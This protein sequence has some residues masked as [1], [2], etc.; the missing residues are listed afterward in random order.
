MTDD[1][2]KFNGNAILVLTYFTLHRERRSENVSA[3]ANQR[4]RSVNVEQMGGVITRMPTNQDSRANFESGGRTRTYSE[5]S[6]R[7]TCI[8]QVV[9][10]I[11]Y[12]NAGKNCFM[13]I[14]QPNS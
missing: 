7:P 4:L 5:Y 1:S 14:F 2:E 13:L 8:Y 9:G 3:T 11:S 6:A 10:P 12:N